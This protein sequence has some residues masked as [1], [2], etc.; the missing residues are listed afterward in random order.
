M[1]LPASALLASK[2]FEPPAGSPGSL[3]TAGMDAGKLATLLTAFGGLQRPQSPDPNII[4]PP[5]VPPVP[6]ANAAAVQNPAL[7]A[8]ISQQIAAGTMPTPQLPMTLGQ[9]AQP[10]KTLF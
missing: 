9:L 10:K 2:G 3:P 1:P 5:G 4:R 6:Q 7:A 8:A